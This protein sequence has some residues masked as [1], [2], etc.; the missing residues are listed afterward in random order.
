MRTVL[1]AAVLLLSCVAVAHPD[2]AEPPNPRPS[3][4]MMAL[5]VTIVTT[6]SVEALK[7]TFKE[8]R[9]VASGS[10]GYAFPSGHATLAF[11]LAPVAAEYH[12]KQRTLWY[13]IA[14]GVAWS[15]VHERAHDW[16]DVIAGAALGT[17]IGRRAVRD[18]G[19]VLVEA[20]W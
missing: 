8:P 15:R 14:A 18:G 6:V 11:A 1:L 7:R 4:V 3:E 20:K 5:D 19:I 16:D 13:A 9:P 12:P 2:G 17:L 10:S